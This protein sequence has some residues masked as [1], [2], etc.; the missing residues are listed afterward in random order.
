MPNS[1]SRP[2]SSNS[3]TSALRSIPRLPPPQ[4]DA[5]LFGGGPIYAIESGPNYSIEITGTVGNSRSTDRS[6]FE[7]EIGRPAPRSDR[8]R[9]HRKAARRASR[10][11]ERQNRERPVDHSRGNLQAGS[12]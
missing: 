8:S 6:P 1:Y 4:Q 5:R 11:I 7:S 10:K 12:S 2:I 3:S 9:A